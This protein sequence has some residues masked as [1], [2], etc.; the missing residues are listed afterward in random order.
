MLELDTSTTFINLL[1]YILIFIYI[2]MFVSI[3]FGLGFT[4]IIITFIV[5]IYLLLNYANSE[6]ISNLRL[7]K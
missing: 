1:I 7:D 3:K 2:L 6:Y 5:W 4:T